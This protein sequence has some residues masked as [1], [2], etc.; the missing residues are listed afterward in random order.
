MGDE[1][2][3]GFRM[4]GV[5]IPEAKAVA[6]LPPADIAAYFNENPGVASELLAESYDKRYA[7]SS[8][9]EEQSAGFE[10]GWFSRQR[11]RECVKRFSTLADAATD[12]LLFSLGKG[13][14][15]RPIS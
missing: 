9:I 1:F 12:Y 3:D 13:R 11:G 8:Y 15:T 5:G 14:W 4:Q 7:P 2:P 10:V 6:K